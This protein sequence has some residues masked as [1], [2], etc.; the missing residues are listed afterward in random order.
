MNKR[1]AEQ[2]G[3]LNRR[4]GIIIHITGSVL[5]LEVLERLSDGLQVDTK[6]YQ[7]IKSNAAAPHRVWSF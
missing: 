1:I 3:G 6:A 2:A 4:T 7:S 5:Y